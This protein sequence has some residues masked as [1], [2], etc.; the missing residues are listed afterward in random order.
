[1]PTWLQ[2]V[3]L[4]YGD[5]AGATNLPNS[6][7]SVDYR[8][9]FLDWQHLMESFPGQTIK[10]EEGV[11]E[12]TRPPYVLTQKPSTS[13][14]APSK[15]RRRDQVEE[16]PPASN[17]IE[18]STYQIPNMGPYPIDQPRMNTTRFT[19][20]QVKA[21]QS[22]TNPGLTVILGPPGTGKT[23]VATQIISNIYHN[24]PNQRTLLIAHSNQALNQL[25]EKI[26][27]LD[28]DERHLLRLG[29]G[30]EGLNTNTSYS[31]QGRVESF[32][33][34]RT[35]LLAEVDR[36][37][38][39]L[40]APGAHGDSC[41][42]AG[43]FFQVYVPT[44]W[45]K[46]EEAVSAAGE[47]VT[48]ELI[49]ESYPF[50]EYFSNTSIPMF[51][52]NLTAAQALD[53]AQGGYRHIRKIFSELE[54]IRP[55]ELLR[56]PRDRQTYLLKKEAR[57]IAMTST[58]AA[59]KR[60]D[61]ARLGFHYDNIVLEEAAQ[62]TEIDT[63]IPLA[64]QRPVNSELPLQRIVLC[65]DHLQNSPILQNLPLKQY[66]NLDQSLFA[67]LIR[68]GVPHIALDQQGRARPAIANLYA[69]RYNSL[70]TLPTLSQNPTFI[71]ANA[72]FSHPVQFIN[73]PDYKG[74]GEVSPHANF[75]QNLGE[76]EYAVAIFQYM[77]LLGY[78][79]DR[80]TILTPYTGQRA[81]IR[82]VLTRRCRGIPLFGLPRA[83]ATVDKYQ[84]E[85]NDYVILSL[86]RTK[87]VGYLRDIRRVTVALSRARLGLY[88]LGRREVFE[89]CFE[90]KEAFGRLFASGGDG[91]LELVTGEMWPTERPE[92]GGVEE[93]RRAVMEGVE[94]LGKYVYEMTVTK[95]EAL[96]RQN[97]EM[98]V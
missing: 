94:H 78:P 53:I 87:R 46:F 38:A 91:R 22:G 62:I 40:Q 12:G 42:T 65:G 33:D 49:R 95:V 2:E 72:G 30:E 70:T 86:V 92:A 51:P 3:F 1:M 60:Q 74:A 58:H 57:I 6:P 17:V 43:Y 81:L 5:P 67:R 9:T 54:D 77:R 96:K 28:I 85:Q 97:Q 14:L 84:G 59:I 19:P 32:M 11:V 10:P 16:A 34:N 79:A 76:A 50:N 45:T 69:W 61:I 8:D 48:A 63:F 66:T 26:T 89:G 24:Y 47:A 39:C 36:L 20:T 29:H 4:G 7:K 35:R 71:R 44:A 41:E 23:D 73:V 56:T 15:K 83:V 55:F 80:I 21:I 27:A 82:D 90:L 52:H 75:L 31:K 68:L 93:G 25:F 98:E 88:V 64:L 37:A 18:V 13:Q